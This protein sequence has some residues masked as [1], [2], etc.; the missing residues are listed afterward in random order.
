MLLND[1]QAQAVY[2][3]MVAL[4]NI[5]ARLDAHIEQTRNVVLR[6]NQNWLGAVVVTYSYGGTVRESEIHADQNAFMN[7]YAMV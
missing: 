5:N 6:V 7:A 3:A 2:S 4:N 1:S